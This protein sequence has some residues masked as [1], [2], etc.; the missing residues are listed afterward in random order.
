MNWRMNEIKRYKWMNW[1]MN[2]IMEN[3]LHERI[4]EWNKN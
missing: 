2:E 4:K 3:E 1:I